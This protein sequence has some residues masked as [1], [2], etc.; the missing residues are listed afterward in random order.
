[1]RKRPGIGELCLS[2]CLALSLNCVV[3]ALAR[4]FSP[5]AF[6]VSRR[7]SRCSRRGGFVLCVASARFAVC[8]QFPAVRGHAIAT[9]SVRAAH[10]EKKVC[11]RGLQRHWCTLCPNEK[12]SKYNACV[13]RRASLCGAADDGQEM[14]LTACPGPRQ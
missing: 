9:A 4:W 1:M 6:H 7:L 3:F 13:R 8:A 2:I 10:T 12:G 5:R 11:G 14:R